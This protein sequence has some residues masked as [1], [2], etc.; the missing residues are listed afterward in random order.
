MNIFEACI[1]SVFSSS[2]QSLGLTL[3]RH[4]HCNLS[5]S[6][7]NQSVWRLGL[8]LFILANLFGSGFQTIV[9]PLVVL[10]PLQAV[11][12][13]FNTVWASVIL[14][15]SFTPRSAWGTALVACGAAAIAGLGSSSDPERSFKEL[16]SQF[17]SNGF[18]T[19]MFISLVAAAG[20]LSRVRFASTSRLRGMLFGMVS[21]ILSAHS[22]L[23]AKILGDGAASAVL[24]HRVMEEL[25]MFRLWMVILLFLV[26][27]VTQLY[28]LNNALHYLSTSIL[29]PLVFCLYNVVSMLNC[30]AFYG[31]DAMFTKKQV[32]WAILGTATLLAGVFLLSSR[33]EA[34]A[35]KTTA[36]I[37]SEDQ[38]LL[39]PQYTSLESLNPNIATPDAPPRPKHTPR[40]VLSKEQTE[41]LN[42]LQA[43]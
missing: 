1:L 40:R 27:A 11:G 5:S 38:P 16:F 10:C 43:A 31:A 41:I 32:F 20:L 6:P 24:H 35:Q 12:L 3:Q 2:I 14:G 19:W 39:A 17:H 34:E 18:R 30:L 7:Q 15:E 21:G 4:A 42:E 9:L 28:L 33:L 23:F 37:S 36:S 13:V 8:T 29:Y 22:L 25:A 26:F